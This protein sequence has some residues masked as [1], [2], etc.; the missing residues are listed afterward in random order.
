MH[1]VSPANRD[2]YEVEALTKKQ[3]RR[4]LSMAR[5]DVDA[6]R[7]GQGGRALGGR[8]PNRDLA[9]VVVFGLGT[10]ARIGE[11]LAVRVRDLSLDSAV[12]TVDICGTI[13]EPRGEHI[14]KRF[15]QPYPKGKHS[16]R[17]PLAPAVVEMLRE[18]LAASQFTQPDDLVFASS[19]GTPL[20]AS[21]VRTRLRN[22]VKDD[23]ELHGTSPHTL[24]RT[25]GTRLYTGPGG[26]QDA[27]D[28]LGHSPGGVTFRHYVERRRI[29]KRVVKRL[30]GFFATSK[31]SPDVAERLGLSQAFRDVPNKVAVLAASSA[32]ED[33]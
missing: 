11:I 10:G 18:R 12:P 25:V 27:C 20:W 16:R 6:T 17:V 24:R 32:L 15:R 4:L 30:N 9:D 13:I 31:P 21:N 29:N 8:R 28:V 1:H 14:K 3:A 7:T 22:L 5:D 33:A 23:A 26:L 19:K 2:E